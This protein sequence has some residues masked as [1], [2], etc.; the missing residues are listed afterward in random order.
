MEEGDE[1]KDEEEG[2]V[3]EDEDEEFAVLKALL[4]NSIG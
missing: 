1:E 4:Q 3:D 2:A